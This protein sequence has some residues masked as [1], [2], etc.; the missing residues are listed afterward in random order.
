MPKCK[1]CGS[2]FEVPKNAME[3]VHTIYCKPCIKKALLR[4]SKLP[5]EEYIKLQ[6]KQIGL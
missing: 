5:V 2:D 1:K 6:A 4:I 3:Q